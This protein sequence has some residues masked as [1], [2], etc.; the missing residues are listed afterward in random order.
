MMSAPPASG[1][2]TGEIYMVTVDCPK[3]GNPH[4]ID[5]AKE[6]SLDWQYRARCIRCGSEFYGPLYF[7]RIE[8]ALHFISPDIRCM[9]VP[10]S[11]ISQYD[12]GFV[13][14]SVGERP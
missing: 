14:I 2:S 9:A 4:P 8:A 1:S 5:W 6:V 12:K 3:C 11:R 7:T 13:I 10:E